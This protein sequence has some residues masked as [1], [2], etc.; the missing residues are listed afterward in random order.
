MNRPCNAVVKAQDFESEGPE[1]ESRRRARPG[2]EVARDQSRP[3]AG[4]GPGRRSP[5]S[6]AERLR[7][8]KGRG[9]GR[10]KE[11]EERKGEG[12]G[13][14]REREEETEAAIPWS[15]SLSLFTYSS[16]CE[17]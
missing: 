9:R 7:G 12:E 5:G 1:F 13:K 2:T 14:G 3:G 6:G 16:S 10:G 11:R 8:R 15:P 17:K 4:P